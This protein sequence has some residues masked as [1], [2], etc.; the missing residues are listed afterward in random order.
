MRPKISCR[1]TARAAAAALILIS[2]RGAAQAT[3]ANPSKNTSV[4]SPSG[5]YLEQEGAMDNRFNIWVTP[6]AVRI[7]NIFNNY[8]RHK[9]RRNITAFLPGLRTQRADYLPSTDIADVAWIDYRRRSLERDRQNRRRDFDD[10]IGAA[11]RHIAG[12]F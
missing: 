10:K 2:A 12:P 5:L 3:P 11:Q 9:S 6:Q 1:Q 4:N 7:D 8:R